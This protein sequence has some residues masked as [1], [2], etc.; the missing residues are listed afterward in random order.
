M[1]N[2]GEVDAPPRGESIMQ[3]AHVRFGLISK[4]LKWYRAG[5][6]ESKEDG[7]GPQGE[8]VD[9]IHAYI[10]HEAQVAERA[11]ARKLASQ[12]K[13]PPKPKCQLPP[14]GWM[15]SRSIG[16]DGPCAA[17]PIGDQHE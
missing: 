12:L 9:A 8:L 3:K 13:R 16:H 1:S 15:C 2:D 11:E 14:H 6:P 10:D 5:C 7:E 4:A 17:S